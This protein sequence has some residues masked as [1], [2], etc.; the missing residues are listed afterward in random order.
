MNIFRSIT[1]VKRIS[2]FF[3]K[4][5]D[6]RISVALLFI[7]HKHM[8]K[9]TKAS[10]HRTRKP[11]LPFLN[12]ATDRHVWAAIWAMKRRGELKNEIPDYRSI[13]AEMKKLG[14]PEIDNKQVS[15]CISRLKATRYIRT[16]AEFAEIGE[17]APEV[18]AIIEAIA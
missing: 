4:S 18:V 9:T 17:Q 6:R 11:T 16:N 8:S 2:Q 7:C 10:A 14:F 15:R 5:L 13:L 3:E 12:A 1:D